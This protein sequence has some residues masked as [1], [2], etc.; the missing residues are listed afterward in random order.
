MPRAHKPTATTKKKEDQKLRRAIKRGDVEPPPKVSKAKGKKSHLTR[1]L[2]TADKESSRKLQSAFVKLPASFLQETL[3]LST[4][5]ILPRPI[6]ESN[7]ILLDNE[8]DSVGV[9]SCPQRPPW[10]FQMSKKELEKGEESVF[11]KWL[12]KTDALVQKWEDAAKIDV[13]PEN[14]DPELPPSPPPATAMPRSTTYF[15]RNIEVW[16]QLWRV[17]EISQIILVLLDSRCPLLHYPPSLSTYLSQKKHILVLTKVD[18]AGPER[19]AAWTSYLHA[20]H[21]TVRIIHVESYAERDVSAVHQGRRRHD[22]HLPDAFR[23]RFVQTL[24]EVHAELLEPPEEVK[25]NP[26]RLKHWRPRI[27]TDIDWDAVHNARGEKVGT[28]VGGAIAPVEGEED[29][30]PQ[31]LSVGL[32][33]Q[34]NVGKSSLLNALF[35]THKVQVSKTPGK[36]KHFQTLFWTSEVRLVDCPGLVMPNFVPMEMQALSGI[37][38]IARIS[39]IPSCIHFASERLPLEDVFHL[40][41]P[42]PPLPFEEDKRTWRDPQKRPVPKSVQ[43]T[44]ID[45]LTAYAVDKGW[46]TAQAGRPDIKRAGNSILRTL[47]ESRVAWAFW[48]PET[49][50][51]HL[52]PAHGVWIPRTE[53]DNHAHEEEESSGEEVDANV[54]LNSEPEDSDEESDDEDATVLGGGTGRFAMLSSAAESPSEDE[55]E[56]DAK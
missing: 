9:L 5:L 14:N 50:I 47:A 55:S 8:S 17:T 7:S 16:R 38:P 13:I 18:I 34:P 41:H 21:P 12:N 53:A 24:Q 39:S 20:K 6:P 33:G 44:A 1:S 29:A 31:F 43:W 22:P 30:E 23:H 49:D 10:N 26:N 32:V 48:P 4:S 54:E 11:L 15:E 40:A 37:L 25:S 51:T 28:A 45:V 36:T 19:V 2:P 56:N 52:S 46:V 35:G 42:N 27:K 3:A